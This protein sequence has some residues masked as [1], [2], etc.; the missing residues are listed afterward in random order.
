MITKQWLHTKITLIAVAILL[1]GNTAVTSAQTLD[2]YVLEGLKSNLVVQQKNI[3]LERAMLA[4]KE[5]NGLFLPSINFNASYTSGKGG[6]YFNF[7]LGD[8]LNPVYSTL[9]QIT[10]T[11]QFPQIENSE[12]YLNPY[13]FY[14]A[15]V[16]TSMPLFNT[17][18]L[19]NKS[20]QKQQIQLQAYEV[21][22]Y[23]RELVK[24]IKTAYYN[25]LMAREAVEILNSAYGLVQR[26]IEV[27]EALQRNG[28]AVPAQSMRAKSELASIIAQQAEAEANVLN[29]KRYFNFL[30][31][32]TLDQDINSDYIAT[33]AIALVQSNSSV[34]S[35]TNR[36][37]LKL[38]AQSIGIY[39]TQLAMNKHY[40]TPK[41]SGFIDLGTQA[42]DWAYNN[43][44]RYYLTGFQL[45]IPIFNGFKNNYKTAR[46][47]FDL[48]TATLNQQ[49]MQQQVQMSALQAQSNLNSA[50]AALQ[51][52]EKQVEAASA[53]FSMIE[54]GFKAGTFSQIEYIDARNQYTSAQ[55]NV[56]INRYKVL[57]QYAAFERENALYTLPKNN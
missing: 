47:S 7:P 15:H 42:S 44:S 28:K 23:Q 52:A 57:Q 34:V 40:W 32:R 12:A 33:T 21:E 39:N 38:I 18:L 56:A 3:A 30:L 54:G 9:N 17:D 11:N 22:I 2:D 51:S 14:D 35:A 53:Y 46:T 25:Y 26:N 27:N 24:S 1:L 20:I 36:E 37:E 31:N 49:L 5:A 4:L 29:A 45:D 50:F 16:R 55:L 13:N 10:Q 19:Y 41:L 48:Q 6:R 43:K 8:L